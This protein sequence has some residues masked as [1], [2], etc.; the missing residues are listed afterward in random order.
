MK[1][2]YRGPNSMP[3]I[4]MGAL[5]EADKTTDVRDAAAISWLSGHPEYVAVADEPLEAPETPAEAPPS[6]KKA[7]KGKK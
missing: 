3:H 4:A 7:R 5:F 6:P 1:F 2:M